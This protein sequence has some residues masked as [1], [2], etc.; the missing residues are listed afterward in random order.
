MS[1]AVLICG[2]DFS[3]VQSLHV[4]VESQGYTADASS[5]PSEIVKL[6]LR[7]RYKL[8]IVALG[9]V[10]AEDNSGREMVRL[11]HEVDPSLPV[12]AVSDPESLQ[13]ERELRSLGIFYLLTT[14]L[15]RKELGDV[16]R[17]ALRKP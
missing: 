12:A 1:P 9:S 8:G 16:V 6:C 15:S 4:L 11:L 5:H 13:D 10:A 17:C 7:N 14:P 3:S 2:E